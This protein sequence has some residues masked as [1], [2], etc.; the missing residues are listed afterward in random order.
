MHVILHV[1]VY[2][3]MYYCTCR[4][5]V[6]VMIANLHCMKDDKMLPPISLVAMTTPPHIIYI[7]F[8]IGYTCTCFIGSVE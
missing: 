7:V 4:Y 1:Y 3:C 6:L 8:F 5:Y 2:Y